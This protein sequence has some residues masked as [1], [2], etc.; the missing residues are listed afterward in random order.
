MPELLFTLKYNIC[1]E[2]PV[3][4]PWTLE[5]EPYVKVMKLYRDLRTQ[6][7]RETRK[8]DVAKCANGEKV[9]RVR[10][11]NDDWY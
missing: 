11:Q 7:I 2:F 3:M 4:T 10:A 5:A 8:T 9:I 1:K 6:Q